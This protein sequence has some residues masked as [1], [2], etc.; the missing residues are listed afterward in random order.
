[1]LARAQD[2]IMGQ[3]EPMLGAMSEGQKYDLIGSHFWRY[4]GR[5]RGKTTYLYGRNQ[6]LSHPPR[7][8]D[9][10]QTPCHNQ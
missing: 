4:P 3:P 10:H 5:L 2:M 9:D 6:A 7:R 1:M 8:T